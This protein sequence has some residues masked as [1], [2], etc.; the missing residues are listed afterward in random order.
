MKKSLCFA[1]IVLLMLG[2]SLPAL[3]RFKR[4]PKPS[5]RSRSATAASASP[6]I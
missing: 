6:T 4:K 1:G 3:D 2:A 5:S